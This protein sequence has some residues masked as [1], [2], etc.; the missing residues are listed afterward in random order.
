MLD[1]A[2]EVATIRAAYGPDERR[3]LAAYGDVHA[4]LEAAGLRPYVETRGGLAVCAYAED[5]TLLVLACEDALPLNRDALTGWH[6]SHVPEDE[7]GAAW[8]CVVYDSVPADPGSGEVGDLRLL[9]LVDAA[10]AHLA[11]CS[12]TA[13]AA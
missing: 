3:V 8:R 6:L 9:P 5:G 11:T 7:P 13:R 10:K 1:V 12:R 4:A 2:A